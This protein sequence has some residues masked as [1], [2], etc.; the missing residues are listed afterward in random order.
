M[1]SGL[2]IDIRS[3]HGKLICAQMQEFPKALIDQSQDIIMEIIDR[4][5]LFSDVPPHPKGQMWAVEIYQRI[6][7]QLQNMVFGSRDYIC[8][9]L[10]KFMSLAVTTLSELVA[11]EAAI[12]TM[13][14]MNERAWGLPYGEG[15]TDLVIEYCEIQR[16]LNKTVAFPSFE[17]QQE[18]SS[19]FSSA[20]QEISC[21]RPIDFLTLFRMAHNIFPERGTMYRYDM[22]ATPKG[23][24]LPDLELARK[25]H[26][27]VHAAELCKA[28]AVPDPFLVLALQGDVRKYQRELELRQHKLRLMEKRVDKG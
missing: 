28:A 6:K 10:R 9:W 2:P 14:S 15:E 21:G 25:R 18:L 27:R 19:L 8:E 13:V 16:G 22:F 5:L 24:L 4:H 17:L 12:L 11:A 26:L 1:M 3:R 23:T 20:L 7:V